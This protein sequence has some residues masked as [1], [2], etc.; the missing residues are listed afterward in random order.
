MNLFTSNVPSFPAGLKVLAVDHDTD[1]LYTIHHICNRLRYQVTTCCTISEA[2][3]HLLQQGFDII[4]IETHIPHQDTYA[5]VQ[6]MTSLLKIP[7]IMMSV[8]NQPCSVMNSISNGACSYWTKP[9][10]ENLF[11]NMWQHVVRKA[12]IQTDP[13]QLIETKGLK[14]R[15]RDDDHV[16]KL[17]LAKKTRLEAKGLKKQGRGDVDGSKQPLAKKTRLSWTLDLHQKFL[18]AVNHLGINNAVPK[19]VLKIMDCP[20]LTLGHVASHLQKYRKYLKGGIKKS[21]L[22]EFEFQG[23]DNETQYSMTAQDQCHDKIP[24]EQHSIE[25]D[26]EFQGQKDNETQYSMTEQDQCHNKSPAEQH[27]TEIDESDIFFDLTD[28]FPDF[29]DDIYNVML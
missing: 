8:D 12:F 9:L 11:K 6:Q 23:Q 10:H 21:K 16:S 17:P 18:S 29:N 7:V 13:H 27:C 3:D 4:L 1:V 24:A 19:K 14:K 26:F 25:I 5:F 22:N 20:G 28:L 15:G 2:M